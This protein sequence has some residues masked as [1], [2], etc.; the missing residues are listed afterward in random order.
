ML[1]AEFCHG[2]AMLFSDQFVIGGQYP[3]TNRVRFEIA[4]FSNQIFLYQQL[5]IFNGSLPI[6]VI[7]SSP[8]TVENISIQ[9][10]F[11]Q[12]STQIRKLIV[13]SLHPMCC[14]CMTGI[15]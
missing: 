14:L 3:F 6:A 15:P 12:T 9:C 10:H 1:S 2:C 4:Y 5:L 8:I 13:S 11:T 7:D